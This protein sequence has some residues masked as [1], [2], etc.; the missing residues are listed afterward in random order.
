MLVNE[1]LIEPKNKLDPNLL[2]TRT[3]AINK[4]I[5]GVLVINKD[6]KSQKAYNIL[7]QSNSYPITENSSVKVFCNCDNFKFQWAYVLDQKQSLLNP[8]NGQ[9]ILTP[10]KQTNPNQD[11]GVCKHVY[12]SIVG[13]LNKDIPEMNKQTGKI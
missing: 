1:L 4:D 6:P 5:L 7:I 13:L 10:P 8:N 3:W 12:A 9:F 11:I 2:V